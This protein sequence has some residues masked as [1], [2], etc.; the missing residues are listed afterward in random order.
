MIQADGAACVCNMTVD[1][2]TLDKLDKSFNAVQDS[3]DGV[4][5]VLDIVNLLVTVY[6]P[7]TDHAGALH[8][9]NIPLTV[10]LILNWLLNVYDR[11]HSSSNSTANLFHN[12]G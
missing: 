8:N 9:V 4:V 12:N 2:L 6:D 7:L 10:D 5:G 3:A 11:Y 1:V